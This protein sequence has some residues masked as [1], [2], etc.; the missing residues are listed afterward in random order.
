MTL[1]RYFLN[2]TYT[3]EGTTGF[4]CDK[5]NKLLVFTLER[6]WNDNKRN[7]LGDAG[8]N[9][10]CIPEGVYTCKK[11]SSPKYHDTWQ[12]T[13]VPNR[14]HILFHSANYIDQL[15]G[16]VA[17]GTTILNMNPRNDLKFDPKKKWMATASRDAFK[18][19]H[20]LMPAEFEIE[21]KKHEN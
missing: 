8:N 1:D 11:Y 15:L 12:I 16:C 21:I 3:P 10:S 17:I 5:N 9:S 14:D 13:N 4:I 6:P 18:K 19:F 7:S 20:D 2:R